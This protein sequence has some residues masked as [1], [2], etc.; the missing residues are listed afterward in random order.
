MLAELWSDLR[1][2]VRALMRRDA[3]ERELDTELRDH[4]ERQ[5]EANQRSGMP[6]AEA[7][8]QARLAFGGVEQ[9]KEATRDA[10][11]TLLIESIV[12]DL[13]FAARGLRA[14]PAFTAGVVL[15]LG[16]GNWGHARLF[17]LHRP[18]LLSPPRC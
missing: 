18:A 17:G 9:A 13:R 16:L 14:R 11:G 10:R 5:A 7:L 8:R 2:R 15:T 12:Q 4:I 3:L 1:Y 6:R